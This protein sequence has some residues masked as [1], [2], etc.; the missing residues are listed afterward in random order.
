MKLRF[1][2][3]YYIEIK[4]I[5]FNSDSD[6]FRLSRNVKVEILSQSA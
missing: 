3:K 2:K 1:N 6:V 5:A 4:F